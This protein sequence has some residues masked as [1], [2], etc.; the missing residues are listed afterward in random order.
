MKKITRLIIALLLI[1]LTL[2]SC[3]LFDKDGE[4][5]T[6]G[7]L[8]RIVY[9]EGI[10]ISSLRSS[11]AAVI[12]NVPCVTDDE[13]TV[14][15]EIVIG[16]TSRA[17]TAKARDTLAVELAASSQYDC[18]YLAYYDGKSV[19]LYWDTPDMANIAIAKFISVCVNEKRLDL[20]EGI[21]TSEYFVKS[22]YEIEKYWLDIAAVSDKTVVAAL[23]QMYNS[24]NGSAIV[25]FYANL[26]DGDIGGFYYTISAR[27]NYG[28]LPDIESTQQIIAGLENCGAYDDMDKFYPDE[29]KLAILEFVWNMQSENDGYFYHPQW[30]QDKSQLQTDRY[31]RDMTRATNIISYFTIDTDGDGVAE[32]Q[33]PRYC[34]PNGVKCKAH[35]GTDDRCVFPIVSGVSSVSITSSVSSAVSLLIES[36]VSPTATVSSHPDYT[37]RDAFSAWL[38]EY[39]STIKE[40]SGKAHNLS[41]IRA[42]IT[43][44]GYDDIVLAHLDRVQAEVFEEQL[45]DGEEPTGLWQKNVDYNA[46]WGLLKYSGYYNAGSRGKAIDE[47]YLPYIIKT[48]IKVIEL[49]PDGNYAS[50]DL[51]NQWDSIARV[52][53]N[54]KTYYG[55]AKVAQLRTILRE[56]VASLIN[57]SLL[58]IEDLKLSNG[59]YALNSNG[60]S[61]ARIYGTDI[62]LGIVEGNT[63]STNIICSMYNS[64][65]ECLGFKPVPLMTR[66]DGERFLDTIMTIEP[67]NKVGVTSSTVDFEGADLPSSISKSSSNPGL[68]IELDYDPEDSSNGV[69]RIDS[70]SHTNMDTVFVRSGGTGSDCY[71]FESK[72]YVSSATEI[73]KTKENV[74]QIKLGNLKN[75]KMSDVTY[76]LILEKSASGININ[77]L[78]TTSSNSGAVTVASVG[79]DEWFDLRIEYYSSADGNL[80]GLDTPVTKIWVNR[81]LA[82]VSERYYGS[83]DESALPKNVY[84]AVA[85]AFLKSPST[86]VYLDDCFFSKED[87][88]LDEYDESISDSRD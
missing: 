61:P 15:G 85:F 1:S 9:A 62:S 33:Y 82:Y 52:F 72:I 48:C 19:A 41:S 66:S 84:D 38:E 81:E 39:N 76:M 47:K 24:I 59:S 45:R 36:V 20:K 50:N 71:I 88:I 75:S 11:V 27:D 53:D 65:F 83:Q 67:V 42:E 37:S 46:V 16:S 80:N 64:V 63:N 73:S 78:T 79:L 35:S 17:I 14:D 18:G 86:Y 26:W 28:Y 60:T 12:G 25:D 30:A 77:E 70:P 31:G 57:N 22:E 13:P 29:I 49:A 2:S 4:T 68:E 40:N 44:H 7:E 3:S 69:L 55:D 54:V 6:D 56:N 23:R 21:V 58:K 10:D 5:D 43:Q 32:K 74:L 87:K 34:A 8:S 51:Y